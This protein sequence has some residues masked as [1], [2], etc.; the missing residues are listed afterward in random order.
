MHMSHPMPTKKKQSVNIRNISTNRLNKQEHTKRC[1]LQIQNG[2]LNRTNDFQLTS[3]SREP[4][5][6]HPNFEYV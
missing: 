5:N 3:T 6:K 4:E 1:L 2:N